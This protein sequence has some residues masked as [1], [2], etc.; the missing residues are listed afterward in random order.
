MFITI[1]DKQHTVI[2][3]SENRTD[4]ICCLLIRRSTYGNVRIE[5]KD[6]EIMYA[7]HHTVGH[8]N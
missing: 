2:T 5:V 3:K 7:I 4:L 8:V 6:N 1:I